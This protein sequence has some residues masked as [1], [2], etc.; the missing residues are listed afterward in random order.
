MLSIS[1]QVV[2]FVENVE[3][4]NQKIFPIMAESAINTPLLPFAYQQ[5]VVFPSIG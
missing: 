1:P 3:N 4:G 2:E 5:F